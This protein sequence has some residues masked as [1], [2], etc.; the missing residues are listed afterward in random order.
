MDP[1]VDILQESKEYYYFDYIPF[2][3]IS[4]DY[5]ELEEYFIQTYLPEFAEKLSRILLKMMY[6]YPCKVYL[7]EPIQQTSEINKFP[8]SVDIREYAPKE[9]ADII[10][11]VIVDDFSSVQIL[12]IEP[13]FL[14]SI[15]GEF[16]TA[17]YKPSHDIV[18][19]LQKLCLQEGLFLKQK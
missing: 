18:V 2:E 6:L 7:T 5:L 15:N 16:S 10:K 9:L 1:L 11:K 8:F 4:A 19:L 3:A 17:I 13:Q 14:I 12:F